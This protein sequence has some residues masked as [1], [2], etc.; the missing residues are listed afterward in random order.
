MKGLI[1]LLA[2][3]SLICCKNS[4]REEILIGTWNCISSYDC[5]KDE[6]DRPEGDEEF[7]IEFTNSSLM[8][9]NEDVEK[10]DTILY[11]WNNTLD[12]ISFEGISSVMVAKLEKD[13][14]I[15]QWENLRLT[16]L[17]I[18]SGNLK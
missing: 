8:Y 2:T 1:I 7:I 14:L 18:E 9:R 15:V 17:R 6:L 4:S 10:A 3:A 5:N 13:S 16:F 11:K 12:S